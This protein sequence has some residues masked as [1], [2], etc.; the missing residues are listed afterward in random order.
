M[1]EP[2]VSARLHGYII[3]IFYKHK[4]FY[5]RPII[6]QNICIPIN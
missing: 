1:E 4:Q 6:L 5:K 3:N 2:L